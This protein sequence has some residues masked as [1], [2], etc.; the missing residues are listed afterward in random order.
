V[1][2]V[3][4]RHLDEPRDRRLPKRLDAV[5]QFPIGM[6]AGVAQLVQQLVQPLALAVSIVRRH[7]PLVLRCFHDS[8]RGR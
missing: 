7:A 8:P 2:V 5:E 4:Q 1:E 3:I 6:L